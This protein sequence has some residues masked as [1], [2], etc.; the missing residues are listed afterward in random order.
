MKKKNVFLTFML[1]IIIS[2]YSGIEYEKHIKVISYNIWNGFE[3]GK[4]PSEQP[5]AFMER[6][7]YIL[8]STNLADQSTNAYISNGAD[9][10]FLSDHYPVIAYFKL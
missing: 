1:L 8:P 2:S 3:W 5:T 6:I 4:L 7:D 9:N 10:W